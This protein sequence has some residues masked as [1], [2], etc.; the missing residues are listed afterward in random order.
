MVR[1]KLLHI[2]LAILSFTLNGYALNWIQGSYTGNATDNRAI[3]GL[4]MNPDVVI[5]KGAGAT[6]AVIK[7]SSMSG[8]N[9]KT[10]DIAGS[11]ATTSIKS[12]GTNSFTLGTHANVNSSG[13]V[14]YFIAFDAGTD[15]VVSSYTGDGNISQT[16]TGPGFASEMVI[17]LS[18]NATA[19]ASPSYITSGMPSGKCARFG[20]MGLW[21]FS[22]TALTATGFTVGSNNNASGET[23]YYAAFKSSST[24]VTGTYSGSA[25][26]KTVTTT[27]ITPRFVMEVNESAVASAR[28]CIKLGSMPTTTSAFYSASA[29]TT[30][31]II[32]IN[33]GSFT[34]KG[35]SENANNTTYTNYYVAF[36][37]GGQLPIELLNFDVACEN[38]ASKISWTTASENN[39]D[40][41]SIERSEDGANF[42][43]IG[44]VTGAGNST[45]RINYQFFDQHAPTGKTS[46]YRLKQTD[47][48]AKYEYFDVKS[49]ASCSIISQLDVN[50][51]PNPASDELS[52]Q[53]DLENEKSLMVEIISTLGRVVYTKELQAEKGGHLLHIDLSDLEKGMYVFKMSDGKNQVTKRITKQ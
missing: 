37:A 6:P 48:D 20:N 5:I 28:P 11:F 52:Y 50:L 36:G 8:T 43:V 13:V 10:M 32:A 31:D 1:K 12:L 33:S 15:L 41:F 26:D 9:S 45:S 47:Y 23:Y 18:D 17:I 35:G 22:I 39:N 25:S 21:G 7:M 46:Y 24:I 4:G 29:V 30:S 49:L 34:V 40:Y 53:F 44:K 51:Y 14:Y 3:S 27:G 19:A 16:V 38:G 2:L 42:E